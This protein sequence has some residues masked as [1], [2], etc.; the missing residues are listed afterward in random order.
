M[1][2]RLNEILRERTRPLLMGIVNATGDSFSD[3]KVATSG[4]A[5]DRALALLDD[6]A[7]LLDIGGE[8]TR[9]GS[10]VISVEEECRRVV[11]LVREL[12]KLRPEVIISVDTRKAEVAKEVLEQGA[13]IINDVSMLRFSPNMA[14]VVAKFKAA[15]VVAHSRGTPQNMKNPEFHDYG[16]DLVGT[17]LAELSEAKEK[18][19][20]S[21]IAEENIF[22]DPDF[23]FAKNSEQDWE[24][25][26]RIDELHQLGPVVAGM[27][28]KSFLGNFLEQPD[29]M[30]RLGGTIAAALYLATREVEILRVHDV[31]QVRDALSVWDLLR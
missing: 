15:L 27:S 16:D 9:P 23:G 29:P 17:V 11:S 2:S 1:S 24:L 22:V 31:R 7:D 3:A 14:D 30:Q 10:A 21:G 13:N 8:S 18:A 26:R 19:I 12:R 6:G 20:Q 5:L 28:R 4:T 25:L